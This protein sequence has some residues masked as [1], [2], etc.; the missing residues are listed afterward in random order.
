MSGSET[1]PRRSRSPVDKKLRY[2]C[3]LCGRLE[4]TDKDWRDPKITDGDR[5]DLCWGYA[6]NCQWP[7]PPSEDG[8]R[9]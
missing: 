5:D 9:S 4:A 8:D 7:W 2:P 3:E 6:A 1:K